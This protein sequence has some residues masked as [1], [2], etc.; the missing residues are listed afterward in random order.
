MS[1][2]IFFV[3]LLLAT[4]PARAQ[5]TAAGYL[6]TKSVAIGFTQ[7]GLGV[8]RLNEQ[9]RAAGYGDITTS[10]PCI[11]AYV[12]TTFLDYRPTLFY[13][14]DFGWGNDPL[15][16]G[17]WKQWNTHRIYA[18]VEYPAFRQQGLEV[19]G[20]LGL[21]YSAL[22]L[23]LYDRVA[24]TTSV[25]NYLANANDSKRLQAG[26]FGLDVGLQAR[27]RIYQGVFLGL[28]GGYVL[29]TGRA[30]WRHDAGEMG[31]PPPTQLATWYV[32][33]KLGV[34]FRRR[35]V[36]QGP[37]RVAPVADAVRDREL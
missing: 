30:T 31:M 36:P 37:A 28:G 27:V 6:N 32:G 17:K 19:Y 10:I 35:I 25:A 8:Q 34:A 13:G 16:Q 1:R 23:R 7:Q 9:L 22:R 4:V 12:S 14:A 29:N 26:T 15:R 3:L 11:T 21:S 24:D 18:G 2:C 20:R 5:D 33:A